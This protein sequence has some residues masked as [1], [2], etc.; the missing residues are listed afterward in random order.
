MTPPAPAAMGRSVADA[1]RRPHS[2]GAPP[3]P[4][5]QLTP[6]TEARGRGT[7]PESRG[8]AAPAP[9]HRT[10]TP[11]R[12]RGHT[13]YKATPPS[14]SVSVGSA[15]ST[16]GV[17]RG[18]RGGA[19]PPQQGGRGAAAPKAP[20]GAPKRRS[21]AAQQEATLPI[22]RSPPRR[23]RAVGIGERIWVASCTCTGQTGA[24]ARG[25]PY[26]PAVRPPS[27]EDYIVN[28][29]LVSLHIR[30]AG[31]ADTFVAVQ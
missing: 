7:A 13:P 3:A 29:V 20:C 1:R 28:C 30:V 5:A 8:P 31:S 17:G 10:R 22:R 4:R 9:M 12:D 23:G 25:Y 14:R 16:V 26:R 19:P 21:R 27:S 24:G 18:K 11:P 15:G 6:I 2:I